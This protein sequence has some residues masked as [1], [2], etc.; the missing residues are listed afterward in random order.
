VP[1][2]ASP[3]RRVRPVHQRR[4]QP[5]VP[6]DG[7]QSLKPLREHG[8][9]HALA[10]VVADL[11]RQV[12]AFKDEGQANLVVIARLEELHRLYLADDVNEIEDLLRQAV[13]EGR[14]YAPPAG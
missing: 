12:A 5:L 13:K 8:D 2:R 7:D 6:P 10:D 14:F 1:G 4:D 11:L 9:V 3:G